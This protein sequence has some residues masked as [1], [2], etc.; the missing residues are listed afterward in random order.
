MVSDFLSLVIEPSEI[1]VIL[2][3]PKLSS[4]V[5]VLLGDDEN[6]VRKGASGEVTILLAVFVFIRYVLYIVT[7]SFF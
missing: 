7:S 6:Y 3:L 4:S 5:A 1:R 2:L